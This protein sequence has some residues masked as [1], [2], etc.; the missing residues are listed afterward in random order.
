MGTGANGHRG[1][2]AP[3]YNGDLGQIGTWK[4]EYLGKW[5]L[6]ENIY[7]GELDTWEMG[8]GA[9]EFQGKWTFGE[10][11]P[12]SALMLLCPFPSN[13][14]KWAVGQMGSEANGHWGKMNIWGKGYPKCP[15]GVSQVP[16][17]H[18]PK[19]FTNGHQGKW[20]LGANG[21]L[22][23]RR[24]PSALCPFSLNVYEWAVG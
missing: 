21:H 6:E 13:V 10:R 3:K 5:L 20:A 11:V 8:S 7:L 16:W 24:T 22:G 15:K 1:K 18:Y 17:D 12:P 14:C 2:W 9:N 4:N 19:M 23:E